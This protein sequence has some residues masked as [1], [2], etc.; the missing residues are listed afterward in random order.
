M[1]DLRP[2]REGRSYEPSRDADGSYDREAFEAAV[3]QLDDPLTD[4]LPGRPPAR[5]P[6]PGRPGAGRDER[7][8][9]ERPT[10]AERPPQPPQP[11]Q[12]PQPGRPSQAGQPASGRSGSPWFRP[13][14]APVAP[15][16][17]QQGQDRDRAIPG[18]DRAPTPPY[19]RSQAPAHT[20]A[21]NPV[22][23]LAPDPAP[24]P[25]SDPSP[26]PS[27]APPPGPVTAPTPAAGPD[28]FL[29]PALDPPYVPGPV[30]TVGPDPAYDAETM[31]LRQA[32]E[33]V[34]DHGGTD[35]VSRETEPEAPA[36]G[37]SASTPSTTGGR[38]ARRKAAQEAA[39]RGNRRARRGSPPGGASA[40]SSAAEAPSVPMTRMEA[41][42]A[43]RAGKESP[44]IIVSRAVGEV[45]ITL[46]VLM[47]LFVTY[48]LWW[49]NVLAHQQ[50]G[51]T[52]SN[53]EHEWDEGG[54]DRRPDAFSPGQGFAIM[55]IPKLDVK[56]PIAEGI[57]KP[58]VLDRGMI[59]HYDKNSVKTAMPWDKQGNFA[60][61]GHRN[62]HGEPFRYINKLVKGDKIVVETRSTYYTYTMESIL[63]QTSPRDIA[64]LDPVPRRS[65]FTRPGRYLTLTTCTPEFTSTF[66][67]IVWGKMVEERPRSKGKP[68]ALVS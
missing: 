58:A 54:E 14:Q 42:R 16:A 51:G 65:G 61:A 7:P 6:G 8:Q 43:E 68:D 64:V 47:L 9:P 28:P 33:P 37:S 11:A 22:P 29:N 27:P 34:G 17:Q 52:A 67:M 15:P 62:T 25:T 49:T 40:A 12:P 10:G 66:R 46:G 59:G 30:G 3:G 5:E 18:P 41:R 57:S 35:V 45:F 63:P 23:H 44:G 4:P 20:A 48:Q 53:L 32:A 1:T 39:K 26:A 21:P 55:Y 31:A 60:V 2:G 13:H 24:S 38:A 56:V 50:A 36:S 19:G